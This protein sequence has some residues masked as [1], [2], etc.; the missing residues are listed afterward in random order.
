MRSTSAI[1]MPRAISSSPSL[2]P[3]RRRPI[4]RRSYAARVGSSRVRYAAVNRLSASN[5]C[6]S[7]HCARQRSSPPERILS[8]IASASRWRGGDRE[9]PFACCF[10][11]FG[12]C[13]Q[14]AQGFDD[15]ADAET[16]RQRRTVAVRELHAL[17]DFA[18]VLRE[19][20]RQPAGAARRPFPTAGVRGRH[21]RRR[22]WRGLDDR[23][24]YGAHSTR[25]GG[26]PGRF[27]V[28]PR[29]SG[30]ATTV[31][32]CGR[33]RPSGWRRTGTGIPTGCPPSVRSLEI[34]VMHC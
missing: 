24:R 10:G 25:N 13:A 11:A 26:A 5:A 34:S 3:A 1:R 29:R 4:S 27:P 2:S 22:R 14:C 17:R 28:T 9:S 12:K 15:V 6:V 33:R 19:R 8:R 32:P 18:E 31:G 23:G 7:R 30:P 16:D 20:V 21:L